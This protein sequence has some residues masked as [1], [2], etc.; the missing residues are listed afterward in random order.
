MIW[1]YQLHVLQIV[2]CSSVLALNNLFKHYDWDMDWH[3]C[4]TDTKTLFVVSKNIVA[5]ING[6]K[7]VS[8]YF[9]KYQHKLEQKKARRCTLNSILLFKKETY[10]RPGKR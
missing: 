2:N 9:Q 3:D 7:I 1:C 8:N 10:Q 4:F 5:L 6:I